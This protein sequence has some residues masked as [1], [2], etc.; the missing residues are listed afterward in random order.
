MRRLILIALVPLLAWPEVSTADLRI[1]NSLAF[2]RTDGSAVQ[3]AQNL[4]VWCGRWDQDVPRRTLHI[5]A[6]SLGGPFWQ[7]RVVVADVRRRPVVRLPHSFVSTKPSGAQLFAVDGTNELSSS[8]E[9]ARGRLSFG[10]VRCGRRLAVRFR[11]RAVLGSEFF[12]GDPLTVRGSFRA[13]T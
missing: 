8:V 1:A 11:V 6:G 13:S 9:E 4:R 7:L 2:T 5:Q 12:E 3:F 10:K